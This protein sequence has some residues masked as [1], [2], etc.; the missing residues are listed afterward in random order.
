M[1]LA[2]AEVAGNPDADLGRLVQERVGVVFEHV[3]EIRLDHRRD[4]VAA[5]LA[6]QL[7][8]VAP[9]ADLDDRLDL[10]LD[11][12]LEQVGDLHGFTSHLVGHSKSPRYMNSSRF[13]TNE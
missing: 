10:F 12:S 6:G 7:V 5:D 11:A 13:P 2:G 8:L 4:D 9:F 1:R 3:V